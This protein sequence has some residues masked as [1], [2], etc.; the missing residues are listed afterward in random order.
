MGFST[1]FHLD[2]RSWFVQ[3]WLNMIRTTKGAFFWGYSGIGILGIDGDCVL[4]G[5]ILFSE[6]G[7]LFR[8]FCSQ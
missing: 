2:M 6:Y 4:L 8:S 1:N 3:A 5:H 7:M